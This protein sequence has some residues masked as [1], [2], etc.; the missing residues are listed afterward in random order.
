MIMEMPTIMPAIIP[1]SIDEEV[2]AFVGALV[3][4]RS[5]T[6]LTVLAVMVMPSCAPRMS[7]NVVLV[8]A[9]FAAFFRE[10]YAILFAVTV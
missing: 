10:V 3:G 7:V 4:D 6:S 9:E 2:G 8:S 1:E 5:D